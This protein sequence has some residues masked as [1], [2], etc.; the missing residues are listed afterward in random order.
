MKNDTNGL[1]YRKYLNQ[2]LIDE[3]LVLEL[4]ANRR[5]TTPYQLSSEVVSAWLR[6]A[7]LPP[8]PA[9]SPSLSV[10]EAE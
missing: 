2:L 4:E 7:S 10:A 1:R 5:G 6:G 8:K 3:Y 9:P